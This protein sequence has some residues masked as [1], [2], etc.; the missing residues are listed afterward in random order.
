MGLGWGKGTR[1]TTKVRTYLFKHRVGDGVT[2]HAF[3]GDSPSPPAPS[4]DVRLTEQTD[5][6]TDRQ[7]DRQR[8]RQTETCRDKQSQIETGR[9]RQRQTGSDRPIDM[10]V[11]LL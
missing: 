5:G 10:M 2:T 6:Q 4:A 7:T 8:Q 3:V 11:A 9:D 1:S